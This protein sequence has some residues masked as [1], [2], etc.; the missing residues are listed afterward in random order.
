MASN[1]NNELGISPTP[2][3]SDVFDG[4]SGQTHEYD[5]FITNNEAVRAVDFLLGL[6]GIQ[7]SHHMELEEPPEGVTQ[8]ADNDDGEWFQENVALLS[9]VLPDAAVLTLT[10]AV[11]PCVVRITTPEALRTITGDYHP[12][13]PDAYRLSIDVTGSQSPSWLQ[14]EAA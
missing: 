2:D 1:L 12:G 13:N 6:E 14:V 10:F 7:R 5:W 8:E 9:R 3:F 11:P 4:P